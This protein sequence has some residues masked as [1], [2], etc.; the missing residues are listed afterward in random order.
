MGEEYKINLTRKELF[1]LIQK[2]SKD[3]SSLSLYKKFADI[4]YQKELKKWNYLKE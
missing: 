4:Y 3:D 2:I 1:Y